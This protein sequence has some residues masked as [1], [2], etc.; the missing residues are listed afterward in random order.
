MT[1]KVL[2]DRALLKQ[3][4]EALDSAFDG[5]A[6]GPIWDALC[7]VRVLLEQ[8]EVGEVVVTTTQQ[9]QCVAVTRQ[10]EEGQILSVIWEAKQP[11]DEQ[12][13]V[14]THSQTGA[15]EC[16][17]NP[18]YSM[19]DRLRMADGA[20][21]FRDQVIANLRSQIAALQSSR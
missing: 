8:P 12:E 21:S 7:D 2:V 9:G 16:W 6:D 18:L 3:N 11:Q 17:K 13:P 15:L 10:D 19:S 14:W 20:V 4:L 1:D 5:H